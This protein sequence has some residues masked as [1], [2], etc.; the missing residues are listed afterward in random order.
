MSADWKDLSREA[1]PEARRLLVLEG[2]DTERF[3]QG[4]V[5][6]D[7]A[8]I[9]DGEARPAS[10]LTVKGKLVSD[11]IM[12]RLGE[13]RYG[14][15]VP[16]SLADEVYANLDRHIIM[17][18]VEVSVDAQ[19]ALAWS[20]APVQAAGVRAFKTSYPAAGHLLIGAPAALAAALADA[21]ALEDAAWA[22]Q[23][24][25]QGVPAWGFEIEA[26]RF[27]P[28]VGFVDSVSYDKGCFMGQEPLARIH[29]R[30]QVNRVLVRVEAPAGTTAPAL[31]A[32]LEHAEQGEVGQLTTVAAAGEGE[33]LVGLAVL[34]RKVSDRGTVVTAGDAT[35]S[36]ASAPLGDDPGMGGRHTTST[37]KLGGPR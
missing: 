12:M 32:A 29:A 22:R 27:P 6:Q 13:D 19:A 15:A 33:G 36:V 5:S 35:F 7:V 8:K 1:D 30:G 20:S 18:E 16:A 31:P 28:E 34:R 3:L 26:G 24:I 23:R 9:E 14:M 25:E 2:E 10:L 17:D 37:V 21:H 11:A 4:T